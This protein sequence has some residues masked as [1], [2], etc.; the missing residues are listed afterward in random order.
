MNIYAEFRNS[1]VDALLALVEEGVL[2]KGLDYS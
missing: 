1:V 2:S